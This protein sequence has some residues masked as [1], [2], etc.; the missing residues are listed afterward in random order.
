MRSLPRSIR[1]RFDGLGKYVESVLDEAGLRVKLER[2]AIQQIQIIVFAQALNE[3]L[4]D[5]S[6]A[7]ATAVD[8]LAAFGVEGFRVGSELFGLLAVS[9][10]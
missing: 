8:A 2:D 3:F 9:G 6:E 5:G 4:R 7:A 1:Q 10:G